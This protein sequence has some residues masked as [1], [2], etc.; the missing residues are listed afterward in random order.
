MRWQGGPIDPWKR[1]FALL[2][3]TVYGYKPPV[4]IWLKTYW[5]RFGGEYTEVRLDD[6]YRDPASP[7]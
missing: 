1:R 2:P 6:P 5:A 7:A 3:I 4:T